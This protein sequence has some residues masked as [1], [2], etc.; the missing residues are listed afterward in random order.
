MAD[1]NKRLG[2]DTEFSTKKHAYVL[3]FPW[4]FDEIIEEYQAKHRP[5]SSS[6]FWGT[7]A[8]NSGAFY[9]F[10][11]LFREFHQFC[12]LYDAEGI[13][14]ICEGRLATAVNE[15]LQRIHFHGL[16]VEM[17]NLTVEQPGMEILKVEITHGLDVERNENGSAQDW[18]ETQSS[19]LGAPCTYY[20]P[21]QD[22][23]DLLDGIGAKPYC[24]AVTALIDSPMKLFVQN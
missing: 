17:A 20:T 3:T 16:D 14:R 21:A 11:T 22:N 10:N 6:S 24:V 7:F 2:V 19:M 4:N 12:A 18:V 1:E 15:S 8:R 5:L 9:E 13:E 23:R